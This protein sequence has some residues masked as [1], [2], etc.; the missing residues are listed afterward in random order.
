MVE[1]LQPRLLIIGSNRFLFIG[2]EK[3]FLSVKLFLLDS[4]KKKNQ[5]KNHVY[6][7]SSPTTF[8]TE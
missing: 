4:K 1:Q 5:E 3:R 2:S 7:T 8:V 6:L